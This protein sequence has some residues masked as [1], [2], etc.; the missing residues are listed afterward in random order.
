MIP[1]VDFH[2]LTRAD[3]STTYS[4]QLFSILAG[5]NGP[6]EV[7]RRDELPE[8]AAVEV[9]IR[10]LAGIGGPRERWLEDVVHSVLKN[11]VL[12]HLYPRSL[13]QVTLQITK[14]PNST[15]NK[16]KGDVAI[17]P[18][19]VNAAFLGLLDAG[20]PLRTTS[21]ATLIAINNNNE[22]VI[23][24]TSKQANSCSSIHAL[25]YDL[26]GALLLNE[27]IGNFDIDHWKIVTE[28]AREICLGAFES[29]TDEV[30]RGTDIVADSWLRQA[31]QEKVRDAT[32]HR[33][34]S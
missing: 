4:D 19:L 24:P 6:V 27:S 11:I 14:E 34:A 10:P 23:D 8:E 17:L 15:I 30:M 13:V 18:A 20:L 5:V 1:Q 21:A 25:A 16:G 22:L 12:V 7:Q 29:G 3:G 32:A 9:N 26:S 2:P 33:G 31:L 28:R